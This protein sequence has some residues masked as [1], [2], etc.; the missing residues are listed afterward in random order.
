MSTC[1]ELLLPKSMLCIVR[2][3]WSVA[4]ILMVASPAH[5]CLEQAAAHYGVPYLLPPPDACGAMPRNQRDSSTENGGA[6]ESRESAHGQGR[7]KRRSEY[8]WIA[9][10]PDKAI[11][12]RPANRT[13][14]HPRLRL[15]ISEAQA[16]GPCDAGAISNEWRR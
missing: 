15:P 7:D 1:E 2:M 6:N 4:I 10:R 11:L 3:G 13:D 9:G 5:A 16:S 12:D 14:D 8:T